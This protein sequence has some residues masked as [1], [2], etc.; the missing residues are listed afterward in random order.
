M[1][2]WFPQWEDAVLSPGVPGPDSALEHAFSFLFMTFAGSRTGTAILCTNSSRGQQDPQQKHLLVHTMVKEEAVG[3][4]LV[5][6]LQHRKM[7]AQFGG[8]RSLLGQPSALRSLIFCGTP[9]GGSALPRGLQHQ[10][11]D[12]ESSGLAHVHTLLHKVLNIII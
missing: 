8:A 7:G 12:S 6:E 3:P 5:V 11:E 2:D 1:T 4:Q 9:G 10:E